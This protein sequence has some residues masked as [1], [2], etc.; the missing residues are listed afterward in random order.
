VY[1]AQLDPGS[2]GAYEAYFVKNTIVA[3]G[4]SSTPKGC[5]AQDILNAKK[6]VVGSLRCVQVGKLL[7]ATWYT[8]DDGVMGAA[9]VA[10]TPKK[11]FA[12]LNKNNL[13]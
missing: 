7:Y 1:L 6:K 2:A 3:G 13:L 12:Y 11:L 9:H 10:T 8:T 5:A 4:K